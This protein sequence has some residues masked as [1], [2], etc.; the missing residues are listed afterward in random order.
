MDALHADPAFSNASTNYKMCEDS[1]Q[2][3]TVEDFTTSQQLECTS[4]NETNNYMF[5]NGSHM[6]T[7]SNEYLADQLIDAVQ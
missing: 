4:D 5:W 7:K 1:I 6:T 3:Q 2:G